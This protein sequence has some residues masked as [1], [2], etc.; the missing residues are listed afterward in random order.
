MQKLVGTIAAAAVGAVVWQAI[1]DPPHQ[2]A[3]RAA[4]SA[5]ADLPSTAPVIAQE[6][7]PRLSRVAVPSLTEP[8]ATHDPG[9]ASFVDQKYGFLTVPTLSPEL[10]E[11]LERREALAV[12]LNTLRQAR[13]QP[14]SRALAQTELQLAQAEERIRQLMH[15]SEYA[16]YTLLRDANTELHHLREYA[17]GISHVVP[18][19]HDEQRAVLFA[20]LT[21]KQQYEQALS[22]SAIERSELPVWQ[23]LHAYERVAQAARASCKYFLQQ[24]RQSLHDEEQF[25][26]L[27]NYEH[28]ELDRELARLHLAAMRR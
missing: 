15:P 2:T 12:R 6:S 9:L 28:T 19:S 17:G 7:Q 3:P 11:A 24:A 5:R 22:N 18:L 21:Y 10:R 1:T 20:K 26:L 14:D 16:E 25:A 27:S 13:I 23:R 8:D 4:K